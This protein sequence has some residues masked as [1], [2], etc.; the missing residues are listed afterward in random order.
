MAT[1]ST[2]ATSPWVF[3]LSLVA[4]LTLS[5][6]VLAL[7]SGSL[8]LFEAAAHGGTGPS[9]ELL[10]FAAAGMIGAGVLTVFAL[11]LSMT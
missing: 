6:G 10:A 4:L 2:R 8:A 9:E 11:L 7:L 3:G 1:A 5:A